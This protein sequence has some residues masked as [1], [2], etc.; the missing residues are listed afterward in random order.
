MLR[1]K[2]ELERGDPEKVREPARSLLASTRT[3]ISDNV[4]VIWFLAPTVSLCSQ[5]FEVIKLQMPAAKMRLLT[6]QINVDTWN[7]SVWKVVLDGVNIIVST[8]QVLLD[9]L[10]HAFLSISQIS[11]LI[12]DEGIFIPF[13]SHF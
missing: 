12:F 4:Q 6:S 9:A 2:A 10:N 13:F 8:Y 11:L 3:A 5:Q 7:E 1:I